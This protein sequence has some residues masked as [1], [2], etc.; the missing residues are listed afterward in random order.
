MQNLLVGLGLVKFSRSMYTSENRDVD[1]EREK[2]NQY[3]LPVVDNYIIDCFE[4]RLEVSFQS[5]GKKRLILYLRYINKSGT[6]GRF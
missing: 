5:S 2:M 6:K 4:L 3:S 1:S